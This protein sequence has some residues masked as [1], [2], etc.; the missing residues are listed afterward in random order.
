VDD[1]DEDDDRNDISDVDTNSVNSI[2]I[3][4]LSVFSAKMHDRKISVPKSKV[5]MR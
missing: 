1:D 4:N 5:K 2:R 3:A